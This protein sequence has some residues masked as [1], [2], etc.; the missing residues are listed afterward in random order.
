M[1]RERKSLR[2][3]V[4]RAD[5][6]VWGPVD[7]ATL[8]V[9]T[10]PPTRDSKSS[11]DDV[12]GAAAG[13]PSRPVDDPASGR[14]IGPCPGTVSAPGFVLL[15]ANPPHLFESNALSAVAN[16]LRK[17]AMNGSALHTKLNRM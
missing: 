11:D 7:D 17:L 9:F 2:I 4:H 12:I 13:L 6:V 5:A 1:R 10:S 15:S 3:G 8:G 14:G 16:D